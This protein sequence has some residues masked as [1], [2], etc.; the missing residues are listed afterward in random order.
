M[1]H[2]TRAKMNLLGLHIGSL[3]HST[4]TSNLRGQRGWLNAYDARGEICDVS[5]QV[6]YYV[7]LVLISDK[8]ASHELQP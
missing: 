6:Q 8:G 2:D 1:L 3:E 7:L 4:T 5:S